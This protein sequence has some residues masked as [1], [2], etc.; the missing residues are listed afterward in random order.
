MKMAKK[1]FL[2]LSYWIFSKTRALSW[3][4]S[5][6][7][8]SFCKSWLA[9]APTPSHSPWRCLRNPGVKFPFQS[10]QKWVDSNNSNPLGCWGTTVS[11]K[12]ACSLTNR[13]AKL[14]RSSRTFH[15]WHVVFKHPGL[16]SVA[17]GCSRNIRSNF[18][19]NIFHKSFCPFLISEYVLKC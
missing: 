10:P 4:G 12:E 16:A 6:T 17:T 8:E 11:H 7:S 9:P 5:A 14:S 2:E 18:V 1:L 13:E 3:E 15:W 19:R